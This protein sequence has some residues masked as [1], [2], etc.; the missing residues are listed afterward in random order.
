MNANA[1]VTS[2]LAAAAPRAIPDAERRH[3]VRLYF[4]YAV[5]IAVNLAIFFLRIR[6]LQAVGDRPAF[7]S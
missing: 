7:L 6:L 4:L 1:T 5:A 3:R 2:S